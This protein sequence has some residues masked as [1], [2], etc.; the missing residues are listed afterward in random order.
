[1]A[2]TFALSLPGADLVRVRPG[3][4][5][6]KRQL[7]GSGGQV[8]HVMNRAIQGLT[9]FTAASDYQRFMAVLRAACQKFPLEL[10]VY[11]VMPNHWH[12]V[13]RPATDDALSRCMHW[14][15]TTHAQRWR[16]ASGTYGRGAVYQGR[17]RW[18]AVEHDVHFLRVCRYVEQNAPRAHLVRRAD[19]WAW[20]SAWQRL[21]PPPNGPALADWP[22]A[23]PASWLDVL[24]AP[25]PTA[26]L[27]AIR[28]CVR[29]E[30]P[31][32]TD[33]FRSRVAALHGISLARPG[34]PHQAGPA[35][36]HP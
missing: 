31:Y 3:S 6:P 25:L 22:V 8:F 19:A 33:E 2:P 21:N 15:T 9:L 7:T 23:R 28:A 4:V 12:L 16:R 18:V 29:K 13:V 30:R 20:S 5:M 27:D 24:N 10:F 11:S 26:I 35:T 14:L 17:F 1:M 32:G 36:C 34:R